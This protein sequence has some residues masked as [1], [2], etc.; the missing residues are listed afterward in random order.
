MTPPPPQ[1][2][3]HHHVR[4]GAVPAVVKESAMS[5]DESK[6]PQKQPQPEGK[7]GNGETVAASHAMYR[8]LDHYSAAEFPPLLSS[9]SKGSSTKVGSN[10][11]MSPGNKWSSASSYTQKTQDDATHS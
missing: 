7:T 11:K 1:Q 5:T 9:T 3:H 2:Q 8:Q 6:A 10:S 4:L